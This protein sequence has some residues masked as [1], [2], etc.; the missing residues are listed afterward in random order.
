MI[1]M[2]EHAKRRRLAKSSDVS[3]ASTG[4]NTVSS[5]PST[6][7]NIDDKLNWNGFCEV[8][9]EPAFF[10]VMLKN[11]GVSGVKV[12]EVVSLDEEILNDLPRP[13]YGF[14]FLFKW[15]EDDPDKQAQRCPEGVWF[16]NQTVNNACASV[17]LLNIV[18][19]VADIELGDNLQAFKD[20]TKD[21]TPALRGDAIANFKFVKEIHNSFARKMDILNGDLQL[22]NEAEAKKRGRERT[23]SAEDESIAGFHFVAFVPIDGKVWKLDGLERQPQNLGVIENQDWVLQAKP[24]IEDCMAKYEEGQIEFA[25]LGLVKE[26]LSGFVSTLARNVKSLAELTK[27]L[28]SLK[29]DWRDFIESS[30]NVDRVL[31]ENLVTGPDAIYELTQELIEQSQLAQSLEDVVLHDVAADLMDCHQKLVLEQTG[32][33]ASIIEEQQ[34]IRSDQERAASRRH[35]YSPA[36]EALVDILARKGVLK[37]MVV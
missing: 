4:P 34:S 25:I 20:F 18:N 3:D 8:E 14:I 2:A 11:F 32:L 24:E 13:V 31:T 16:A 6:P 7:V 23:S 36:V 27:R 9:S 30:V 5:T 1:D 29:P 15:R 22:K 21:F 33:R 28:D 35:D 10:N 17:A 12:Q 37:D 19:N 26:P